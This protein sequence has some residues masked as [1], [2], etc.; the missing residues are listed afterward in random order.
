MIP[1]LDTQMKQMALKMANL[2]FFSYL[3][4]YTCKGFY[5]DGKDFWNI[6]HE[7][8]TGYFHN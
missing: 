3:M 8:V 5:F 6:C 4:F 7:M 1:G 2:V